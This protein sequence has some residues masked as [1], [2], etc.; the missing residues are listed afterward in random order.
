VDENL[1]SIDHTMPKRR[2]ASRKRA[3]K[4]TIKKKIKPGFSPKPAVPT[5]KTF[6]AGG[7]LGQFSPSPK[8]PTP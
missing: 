5:K 8:P 3:P 7:P 6:V 1:N 2:P 4:K